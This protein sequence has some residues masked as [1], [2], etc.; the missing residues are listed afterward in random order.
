MSISD[1]HSHTQINGNASTAGVGQTLLAYT[2]LNCLIFCTDGSLV[3]RNPQKSPTPQ[4]IWLQENL[5]LLF[6][7]E[8]HSPSV[9]RKYDF[10]LLR[11]TKLKQTKT[12]PKQTNKPPKKEKPQNQ[13]RQLRV[14][15]A[16]KFSFWDFLIFHEASTLQGGT[17]NFSIHYLAV[18]TIH[19]GRHSGL[20]CQDHI[21]G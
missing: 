13:P 3:F 6:F 20:I 2:D 19:N 9:W 15:Y 11:N 12:Q 7:R 1:E 16:S 4:L 8:V 17:Q 21:P 5:S 18:L 14:P 10:F